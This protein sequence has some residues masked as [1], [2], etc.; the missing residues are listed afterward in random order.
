M[1]LSHENFDVKKGQ[2]YARNGREPFVEVIKKGKGLQEKLLK[3]Y[4]YERE[5]AEVVGFEKMEQI[6]TDS[7]TPEG[8]MVIS[9]SP[10][11]GAESSYRQNFYDVFTKT[12]N[13]IELDVTV[14]ALTNSEYAKFLLELGFN[15]RGK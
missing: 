9:I 15:G 2:I 8:S 12:G 7:K 10:P 5:D 6:L 13:E 14:S 4:D 1:Y 11:G 3:S